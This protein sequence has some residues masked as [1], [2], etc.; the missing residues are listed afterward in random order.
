[1]KISIIIPCF[2][3]VNTIHEL[4][5]KIKNVNLPNL[6]K[7]VILV[8]D[9]STDG[10]VE[11]IE[12]E[13]ISLNLIQKFIK[14]N[15]NFGKGYSVR[16]GIEVSSGDIIIIQDA[17]LEYD[18]KDYQKLLNPIIEKNAD[19]VYGTRFNSVIER[20]V[21][22]FW[23]T[24]ANRILTFF[25][26][27]RCNLNLSDMEVGYKVFKSKEIKE[28][29]LKE[30]SFGFEPEVTIKLAKKRLNFYEVGINYYG[31]GYDHGKKIT[32]KDAIRAMYIIL[33][34]YYI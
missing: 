16:R 31:R 14:N 20:K 33:F 7:E 3:E 9:F 11:K 4:L 25:C 32:F 30:N 1:M 27:F 18:P 2:N 26:N 22:L 8:D 21:H 15:Q 24:C 19:V 10:T 28:I 34:K 5:L 13:L 23:N 29:T 12:N 6:T 17:D